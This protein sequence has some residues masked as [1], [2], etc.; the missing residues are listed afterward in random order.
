MRGRAQADQRSKKGHVFP[1][2]HAGLLCLSGQQYAFFMVSTF[3]GELG[4]GLPTTT[5]AMPPHRRCAS[6]MADA[7]FGT[8]ASAHLVSTAVWQVL[9]LCFG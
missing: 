1:V 3:L 4:Q 6:T 9:R 7:T 2:L 5:C 8:L